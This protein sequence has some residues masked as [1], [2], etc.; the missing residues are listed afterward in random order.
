MYPYALPANGRRPTKEGPRGGVPVA[1]VVARTLRAPLGLLLAR[2][3]GAPGQ[4]ELAVASA[5][6]HNPRSC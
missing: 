1:A 6:A 4:P 2:K 5:T 3:I